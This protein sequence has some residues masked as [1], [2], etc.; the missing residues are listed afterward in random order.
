MV[1]F[2]TQYYICDKIVHVMTN[3]TQ[4]NTLLFN[5]NWVNIDKIPCNSLKI[6]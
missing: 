2:L 5:D 4:P 1:Q 3:L 6:Y